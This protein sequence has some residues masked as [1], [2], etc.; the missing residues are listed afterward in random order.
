M[1]RGVPMK[2]VAEVDEVVEA[3]LFAADPKNSFMTGHALA[4]D[5]GIGGDLREA[6]AAGSVLERENGM[7]EMTI[8]V[9]FETHEGLE[10]QLTALLRDHALLT[11]EEEPGCLRFEVLKPVDPDG[12]PIPNR[13]LVSE[14][15]TDAAAVAAHERNPRLPSCA[16][17]WRRS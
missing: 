3:I 8:I 4:I 17:Q 6:A 1:T 15:Y 14:L 11:R 10:P 2:R 7:P 13:L 12:A 16:R 9:E 5:G